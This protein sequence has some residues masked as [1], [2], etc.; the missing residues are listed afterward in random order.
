MVGLQV[1]R[2]MRVV[3]VCTANLCRSPFAEHVLR[4]ALAGRG[5]DV[6]V[7]SAGLRAL[8]GARVPPD[9]ASVA[10]GFSVELGDHRSAPIEDEVSAADLFVTMTADHSRDLAIALPETIGRIVTLGAAAERMTSHSHRGS[11]L[12]ML[13]GEQRASDLLRASSRLDVVDPFRRASRQQ[14]SVAEQI[15]QYCGVVASGWPV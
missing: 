6:T 10:R 5:S 15:V 7:G 14:R 8:R 9:W 1:G 12:E 2:E 13:V 4:S 11:V 3:M